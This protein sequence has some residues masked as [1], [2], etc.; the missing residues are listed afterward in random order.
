MA[1]TKKYKMLKDSLRGAVNKF[2][3]TDD[4]FH[5]AEAYKLIK[6]IVEDQEFPLV[7][8][9]EYNKRVKIKK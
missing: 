4:L 3:M 1:E 6:Q 7:E 9:Q 2:S 5:L 8:F